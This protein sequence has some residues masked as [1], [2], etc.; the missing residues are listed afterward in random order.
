MINSIAELEARFGTFGYQS[1]MNVIKISLLNE[2]RLTIQ[3]ECLEALDVIDINRRF[4]RDVNILPV[5]TDL[6]GMVAK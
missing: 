5:P 1:S 4:E 3:N 6:V 2:I